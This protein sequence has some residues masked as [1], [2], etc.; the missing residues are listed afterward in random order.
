MDLQWTP[1][2]PGED[3]TI[4]KLRN[5]WFGRAR[6]ALWDG[7]GGDRLRGIE[8]DPTAVL[9]DDAAVAT[10]SGWR[11]GVYAGAERKPGDWPG[12]KRYNPELD[13]IPW[14]VGA[15]PAP[16]RPTVIQLPEAQ[17]LE[18]RWRRY[19]D[20]R[21]LVPPDLRSTPT[22]AIPTPAQVNLVDPVRQPDG[23]DFARHAAD[24]LLASL[25]PYGGG[26]Q[27]QQL[28][29]QAAGVQPITVAKFLK[30]GAEVVLDA[31]RYV[32]KFPGHP[33]LSYIG[34]VMTLWQIG[35]WIYDRRGRL[36]GDQGRVVPEPIYQVEGNQYLWK[37]PDGSVTQAPT[38][39]SL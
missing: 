9:D 20:E 24:S 22:W 1:M 2:L 4:Y 11:L 8:A 27:V 33:A 36:F 3:P 35:S 25:A 23:F 17:L 30:K 15:V 29:M 10:F 37:W 5:A 28:A 14:R 12:R 38:R 19:L 31:G 34:G 7:V 39:W 18:G 16:H 6:M 32:L 26:G 21:V 13:P